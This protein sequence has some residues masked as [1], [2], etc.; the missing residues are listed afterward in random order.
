MF[1]LNGI[2]EK[3]RAAR[4]AQ[5]ALRID[6]VKLRVQLGSDGKPL[7]VSVCIVGVWC[8]LQVCVCVGVL[9]FLFIN[10]HG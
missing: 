9:C 1:L 4:F 2:A 8:V 6:G 5:G 7:D 10:I 3:L